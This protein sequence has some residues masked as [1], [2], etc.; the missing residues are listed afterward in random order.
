[1]DQTSSL[2][3]AV[4]ILALHCRQQVAGVSKEAEQELHRGGE[5]PPLPH[6]PIDVTLLLPTALGSTLP[7]VLQFHELGNKL[8]S[9]EKQMVRES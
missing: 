3:E 7:P 6:Q 1:M 9:W 5:V 2:V 4:A 8:R